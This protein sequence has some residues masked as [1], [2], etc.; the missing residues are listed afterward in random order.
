MPLAATRSF[1][2]PN[3]NRLLPISISLKVPKSDK[4]DFGGREGWDEAGVPRVLSLW[5]PPLPPPPPLWGGRGSPAPPPPHSTP[6]LRFPPLPNKPKTP[7]PPI[8]Q[9]K[10]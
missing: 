2:P 7:T 3:R 4:P 6:P 8:T 9:A 5:L 10:P 1:F